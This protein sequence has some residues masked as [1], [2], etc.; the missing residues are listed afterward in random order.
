M[1]GIVTRTTPIVQPEDREGREPDKPAMVHRRMRV[2]RKIG[3]AVEM[4]LSQKIWEM[5]VKRP[6]RQDPFTGGLLRPRSPAIPGLIR[7]CDR[8]MNFCSAPPPIFQ[9]IWGEA[10]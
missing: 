6:D 10:F 1:Q 9:R 7:L 4:I 3:V 5:D 8:A 2:A